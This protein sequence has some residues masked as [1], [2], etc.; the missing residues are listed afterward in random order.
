VPL[1]SRPDHELLNL[2]FLNAEGNF[3]RTH[4]KASLVSR[5]LAI[6]SSAEIR[7]L[8]T[9]VIERLRSK[10]ESKYVLKL[11]LKCFLNQSSVTANRSIT[12][13]EDSTGLSLPYSAIDIDDTEYVTK[14]AMHSA[15]EWAKVS[16]H[17]DNWRSEEWMSLI[18]LIGRQGKEHLARAISTI[19]VD[20]YQLS[21]WSDNVLPRILLNLYAH[22]PSK[23]S[24]GDLKVR[25]MLVNATTKLHHE[26]VA[27]STPIDDKILSAIQNIRITTLQIQQQLVIDCIKKYPLFVVKHTK[28]LIRVLEADAA[29]NTSYEIERG[30]RS[31]QYPTLP[32]KNY[33]GGQISNASIV[34]WGCSF[35]EPLWV[36]GLDILM[37][38]PDNVIFT[39]G[40]LMG[41]FD[42]LS[43]YLSLLQTQIQIGNYRRAQNDVTTITRL[44]NKFANVVKDFSK[45]NYEAF[46]DWVTS[47][48]VGSQEVGELLIFCKIPL[49]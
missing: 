24:L 31:V 6:W 1:L 10:D 5:C 45:T 19:F 13:V 44:R 2:L 22:F 41:L 3:R 14:L 34:H 26:W 37:A 33:A 36:A 7:S 38:F 46:S 18:L 11:F 4:I 35:S 8:Q 27:W 16:S 39:C 20:E 12:K 21:E 9:W 32:L 25:E 48:K 30:R 28:A 17:P 15:A 23:M 49:E 40:P 47:S 29:S 42:V 43:M